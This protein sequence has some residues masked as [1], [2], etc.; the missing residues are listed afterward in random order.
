MSIILRPVQGEFD[1]PDDL[2]RIIG[3][4]KPEVLRFFDDAVYDNED[5]GYNAFKLLT[6]DGS[7]VLKRYE[8]PEDRDAEVKHYRLLQGLP[9]P[10]LLAVSSDCILMDFVEGDDLKR[11]TDDGVRAAAESLCAVMN[12]YPM[13]RDYEKQ[14][15]EAYLRRLERRAGTL[16]DELELKRAFAVFFERQKHIPLTLSNSDLLPINILYDGRRATIID[17]AFGGFMPYSLDIARFTAHGQTVS[18]VTP[19]RMSDEQKELF[20]SLVYEGLDIKP[21]R[22][23]YERDLLLARFNEYI[24]ILEYYFGDRSVPRTE[25]VF[26]YYYPLALEL[27]GQIN[28]DTNKRS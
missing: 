11:P 19:F 25:S 13:G 9:V 3:T 10:K 18:S 12:A 1:I 20:N 27:A 14:R 5:K 4:E 2:K 22:G 17:W 7:F 15:Y 21:S 24:E 6:P 26:L 16:E 8:R 28:R 23:E